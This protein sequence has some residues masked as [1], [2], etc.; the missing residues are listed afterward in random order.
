V[1]HNLKTG[2]LLRTSLSE[3][4]APPTLQARLTSEAVGTF[5]LCL[6]VFGNVVGGTSSTFVALSIASS[7]MIMIYALGEISGAHFNPAV[8]VA[9]SLSK[10]QDWPTT[11]KYVGA[12]CSGGLVAALVSFFIF[13]GHSIKFSGL[14]G[15]SHAVEA[16]GLCELLYTMMLCFVVLNVACSKS[17][18]GN[19]FF[20]LAIGYVIVAGGCAVGSVS[21][22]HL[23]P[24]VSLA[25]FFG[26]VLSGNLGVAMGSAVAGVVG[27]FAFQLAGAY[28]ACQLFKYLKPEDFGAAPGGETQKLVA[29]AVGTFFLVLTAGCSILN[30]TLTAALAI[31]SALMCMI[32][33]LGSLSGANFN[34]SV[35]LAILATGRGLTNAQLAGKYIVAQT[36]GAIVAGLAYSFIYGKAFGLAPA[37][38]AWYSVG[39][40]EVLFTFLLCF[41]VLAVATTKAPS[42]DMFGFAI[43]SCVTVGGFAAAA[44]G[45][46]CLNPAAAIGISVADKVFGGSHLLNG[47]GYALMEVAGALLA[48]GVFTQT[49]ASEFKD[50]A[51]AMGGSQKKSVK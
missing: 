15:G 47:V 17:T 46:G 12:Q 51:P 43:G 23:N 37:E 8:S 27:Y 13:G 26:S 21:G 16:I 49:H 20:G 38:G 41:V 42:K 3:K 19:Q 5:V 9:I 14:T 18:A 29:E 2:S 33:A 28:L 1:H 30:G 25:V 22:G 11:V 32:Y 48:A 50:S 6:T 35:T 4:M 36:T 45:G 10:Q 34:P 31:G 40:A 39:M 7:L 24:A 44:T